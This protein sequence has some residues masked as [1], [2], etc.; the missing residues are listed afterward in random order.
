MKVSSLR[1][2]RSA[3]PVSASRSVAKPARAAKSSFQDRLNALSEE[4]A[5]SPEKSESVLASAEAFLSL[6]QQTG[7]APESR[8][9]GILWGE[10]ML[11]GL[12]ELHARMLAGRI[13][14]ERLLHIA[15]TLDGEV[16]FSGA[17]DPRLRAILEQIRLR[18]R[19]ELAKYG[20]AP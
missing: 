7:I 18:V 11:K 2:G 16:Q 20:H 14:Q 15:R 6:Q 19:V 13:P 1:S 10:D 17:H 8:R 9:Q 4:P 5:P 12:E 3:K